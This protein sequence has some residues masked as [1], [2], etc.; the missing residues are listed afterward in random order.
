VTGSDA[1]EAIGTWIV[2]QGLLGDS[3]TTLVQGFADR[4]AAAGVPLTRAYLAMPSISPTSRAESVTWR[5]DGRTL[6]ESVEHGSF[7]ELWERSPLNY[8][9]TNG[10]DRRRWRLE[11]AGATDA[12]PVF[13]EMRAEGHTDYAAHVTAFGGGTTTAL[14]GVAMTVCTAR[15]G[16]FTSDELAL[17]NR[18]VPILAL[19][20]YRTALSAAAKAVLDAYVGHDAGARILSGEI[21]RG[22]GH[23]VD[24]ALLIADLSGFTALADASGADLVG[25]LGEHLSAI[26]EPIEAAGGEVLKFMGDG[27]LA[28]HAIKDPDRPDLAC[29]ALLAGSREA[30]ARNALVNARYGDNTPLGLDIALHRGPVFYGNIGGGSRLDFTVIGPAV[31]EASRIERLCGELG[32]PILMSDAFAHCCGSPIRSLGYHAL[33]G[34]SEPREIFTPG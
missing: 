28:G 25:R 33:R 31:N 17:L 34:V 2:E 32:Q 23:Q 27:V 4:V 11:E 16:G 8:L 12:F 3:L 30:L 18:L 10:I 21:V 19:A 15:P 5:S 14:R 22:E 24:A 7:P 29:A 26:A 9:I 6:R 1:S 13:A 20:A